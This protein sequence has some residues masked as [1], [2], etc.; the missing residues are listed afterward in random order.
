[1]VVEGSIPNERNKAEGY[2]AALGTD[3]A[4]GQQPDERT[5]RRHRQAQDH[6]RERIHCLPL[7]SS[8]MNDA[9]VLSRRDST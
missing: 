2:W 3:R 6:T 5:G 4:T 9:T 8:P 1:L 7:L